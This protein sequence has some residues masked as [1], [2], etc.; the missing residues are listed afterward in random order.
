MKTTGLKFILI[1]SPIIATIFHMEVFLPSM[2]VNNESFLI[3]YSNRE[4]FEEDRVN[5]DFQW[6][7]TLDGPKHGD[8][9]S[10][11][12]VD[13]EGNIFVAGFHGGIDLD[14]DGSIDLEA[15][16]VD[17][18]F[19][20]L[21]WNDVDK[22]HRVQWF[23]TG[24]AP[25]Y[26]MQ[27]LIAPDQSGGAY[28][29]G[30]FQEKIEFD[31][32]LKIESG[33]KNDSFLVRVD[34]EGNAIWGKAFGGEKDDVIWDVTSDQEGNVYF[35]GTTHGGFALSDNGAEF[36]ETEEKQFVIVSLDPFGSERWIHITG[37]SVLYGFMESSPKGEIYISG[38]FKG[39]ID[40]NGDGVTDLSNDEKQNGFIARLDTD[41]ALLKSWVVGAGPGMLSIA[42]DETV[43]LLGG[44]GGYMEERYEVADFDGDGKADIS[45]TGG[46]VNACI[47]AY[48]SM[49]S[50]QWVRSYN[51]D[52]PANIATNGKWI[53]LTGSYTGIRDLDEDG[54]KEP[55]DK[56]GDTYK[57]TELA[58]ILLDRSDGT[59]DRVWVAPGPGKD[60]AAAVRFYP[61]T[62]LVHVT[63][64][65]QLAADF[66]GD[67]QFNEGMA[68]CEALGDLFFAEYRINP[69]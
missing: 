12:V 8:G 33:G 30:R 52:G 9:G 64:F 55:Y 18:I 50:L 39:T 1:I 45:V 4:I 14:R 62:D 44:A 38:D 59:P 65:I 27:A 60:H 11:M 37:T 67:E 69:K 23:K 26:T 16:A 53:A 13:N 7:W 41:G 51:M 57:E 61:D 43:Y 68:K 29:V 25:G 5:E 66:S 63:G 15:D 42:P 6:F 3:H 36:P 10:D 56:I 19:M 17:P 20:K 54:V 32:G 22:R 24:I 28:V 49:G 58:V 46:G 35:I 47:A 40:F 21:T 48:T 2:E 31:N 34:S